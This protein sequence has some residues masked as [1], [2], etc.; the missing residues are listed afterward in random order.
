MS[1]FDIYPLT[2]NSVQNNIY[3]LQTVTVTTAFKHCWQVEYKHHKCV[4]LLLKQKFTKYISSWWHQYGHQ[5][6]QD[7][8]QYRRYK[9]QITLELWKHDSAR[10]LSGTKTLERQN[11]HYEYRSSYYFLIC[12]TN[13]RQSMQA[14]NFNF[15]IIEVKFSPQNTI[16]CNFIAM[17]RSALNQ[18]LP[19]LVISQWFDLIEWNVIKWYKIPKI[20]HVTSS[21]N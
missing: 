10:T 14:H 2:K 20:H 6:S 5:Q 17:N 4:S 21:N 16:F 11:A 13:L 12:I 1:R 3:F 7:T 19:N 9:C 18:S 15:Y 8:E